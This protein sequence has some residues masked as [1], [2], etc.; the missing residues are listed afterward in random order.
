MGDRTNYIAD[1]SAAAANKATLGGY[2][3]LLYGWATDS[4][5]AI[6]VGLF[7]TLLGGIWAFVAFL[8]KRKEHKLRIAILEEEL[9]RLKMGGAI[10][11]LGLVM[12]E[13]DG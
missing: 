4:S 3:G 6:M 13:S 7:V 10:A 9:R 1:A 5:N 8:Q 2:M 12:R 11:D